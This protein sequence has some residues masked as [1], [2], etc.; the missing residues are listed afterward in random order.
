V[1]QDSLE[2]RQAAGP[3][4]DS[5]APARM[6]GRGAILAMFAVFFAGTVVSDLV[7]LGFFVGFALVAGCGLAAKFTRRGALLAVVI[8]PPLIFL[9]AVICAEALTSSSATGHS[10]FLSAIEGTFLTLASA[11]PWLFAGVAISLVIALF[12]G[13]PQALR[14][15][16]EGLRGQ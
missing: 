6:T 12:R 2:R 15:L 4:E 9:A 11:A 7:H 10:S 1:T 13:L 8:S 14:D 3:P 16:R 5:A